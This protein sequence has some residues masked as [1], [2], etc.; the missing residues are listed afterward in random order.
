MDETETTEETELARVRSSHRRPVD[1]DRKYYEF[2]K[3]KMTSI[4]FEKEELMKQI[5]IT[6]PVTC[7]HVAVVGGILGAPRF[8]LY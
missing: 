4:L 6:R 5:L 8:F 1:I 3:F 7:M 2:R